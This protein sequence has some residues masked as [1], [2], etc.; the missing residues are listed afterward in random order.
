MWI[1]FMRRMCPIVNFNPL[2]TS[3]EYTWAGVYGKCMLKENQIVFNG[4]RNLL[5]TFGSEMIWE[6]IQ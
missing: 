1:E 2:K 6:Y 3:P 4:L 5:I